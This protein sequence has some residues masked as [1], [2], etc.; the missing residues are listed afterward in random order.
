M[1]L[2]E[3]EVIIIKSCVM[4]IFGS[5]TRVLLFGSRVDDQKRGGDIDLYL[6]PT[7]AQNL[8]YKKIELLVALEKALGEQKIDVVIAKTGDD[9]RLIDDVALREGIE[10]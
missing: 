7:D 4:S 3:S 8:Y 1:R 5:K 10:L 9:K 2:S 6:I